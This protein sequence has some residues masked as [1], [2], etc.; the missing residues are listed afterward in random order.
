MCHFINNDLIERKYHRMICLRPILEGELEMIMHWRMLPN[1]T[2]FM[3]SDPVLTLETQLEWFQKSKY[4]TGNIHFMIEY[5]NKPVGI[6]NITDID[7]S[8]Q[9][10][11]WGYYIAAKE[12]PSLK[13]ILALEWNLYDY[14]F[15][16]LGLNKVCGEVFAFN[17]AVIR[18]HQMCGSTIEGTRK[19]HI[20]KNGQFYD[21]VEMGICKD[22]WEQIRSRYHYEKIP[23]QSPE[24]FIS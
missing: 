21:V 7:R 23:F 10:C 2:K 18:M 5:D 14:V 11:E 6:L 12:K 24:N 13:Q 4:D 19:N 1:I 22:D 20:Y 15:Y 8:H 3:Y 17:K 9:R 16:T